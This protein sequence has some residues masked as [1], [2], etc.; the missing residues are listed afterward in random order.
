MSYSK[1]AQA[2][3]AYKRNE[4]QIAIDI[5]ESVIESD[6]SNHPAHFNLGSIY[7]E[8]N[9]LN[10]AAEHLQQAL[11][12]QPAHLQ[13]WYSLIDVLYQA[14][15]YSSVLSVISVL[16]HHI[17]IAPHLKQLKIDCIRSLKEGERIAAY[18][19]SKESKRLLNLEEETKTRQRVIDV[20]A[21]DRQVLLTAFRYLNKYR[22][23]YKIKEELYEKAVF[24]YPV[25]GEILLLKAEWHAQRFEMEA[26][27]KFAKLASLFLVDEFELNAMVTLVTGKFEGQFASF[28]SQSIIS[29]KLNF[30]SEFL[31]K[32]RMFVFSEIYL[33]K[34]S[35]TNSLTPSLTFNYALTLNALGKYK[36]AAV[37]CTE[38]L[39]NEPENEEGIILFDLISEQIN[40]NLVVE[41]PTEKVC[42]S[43]LL[44]DHY[45]TQLTKVRN[46][47]GAIDLYHTAISLDHNRVEFYNNL[48]LAFQAI[49]NIGEATNSFMMALRIDP[50]FELAI[51]NLSAIHRFEY[52]DKYFNLTQDL[53]NERLSIGR[54]NH[55]ITFSLAKAMSD[56]SRYEEA[57][58]L[59][60]Q[61]N[62]Q[63]KKILNFNINEEKKLFERIRQRPLSIRHANINS[64]SVKPIFIVGMP[65]SGT[66]L[67]EQILGNHSQV[68]PLGELEVLTTGILKYKLLQ[69]ASETREFLRLK[70]FYLDSIKRFLVST[71]IITDKMPINFLWIGFILS[72]FPNAK[73]VHVYRN[74]Q[75][76]CWSNFIH[77]FTDDGNGFAYSLDDFVEYYGL[78]KDWIEHCTAT[79]DKR[80]LYNL[81]YEALVADHQ[82][83]TRSLLSFLELGFEENCINFHESNNP[84]ATASSAQVRSK[85]MKS[86]NEK[87]R[88]FEQFLPPNV[89]ELENFQF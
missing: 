50:K 63:R 58:K 32:H 29:K 51:Y 30:F 52:E 17:E 48:G 26:A 74:P 75:A 82:T 34:L 73:I 42:S 20:V 57:Y 6:T 12:L 46:Y 18:D 4:L 71:P 44:A 23:F 62:K 22:G 45:A 61:A 87:W 39:K 84:V 3:N 81:K 47:P 41:V 76:T 24:R 65:R 78:Y 86:T 9:E 59:Y 53:F 14:S 60:V 15:L 54:L 67:V 89:L 35:E 8:K 85:I 28:I 49:G 43:A 64:S 25:D 88:N 83:E 10:L 69:S 33:K 2:V 72:T 55:R 31:I 1:I 37:F 21:S 7:Q 36:Q 38:F 11:Y 80:T 77:N 40:P 68:T 70:Q 27:M 19:W 16:E 79:V 5:L 66:T 56:A 13:T